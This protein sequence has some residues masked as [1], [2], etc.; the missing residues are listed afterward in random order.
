MLEGLATNRKYIWSFSKH[1]LY[2]SCPLALKYESKIIERDGELVPFNSLVGISFH[3]AISSHIVKW[4]VG[5]HS[6]EDD[7]E[8]IALEYLRY[9]WQNKNSKII[10]ILNGF[11]VSHDD[12]RRIE[13]STTDLI[14]HFFDYIWPRF[15]SHKYLTHEHLYYFPLSNFEVVVKPDLVTLGSKGS[16]VVTDWKTSGYRESDL[17]SFQTDIYGLWAY[18]FF[19]GDPSRIVTQI[20]NVRTGNVKIEVQTPEKLQQTRNEILRSMEKIKST[21][22]EDSTAAFPEIDKCKSCRFLNNCEYGKRL[23]SSS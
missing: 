9:L 10:E 5:E 19:T 6:E 3:K 4:S 22:G 15:Y 2:L 23:M 21:I 12:Q 11:N 17:S 8:K 20:I 18:N 1:E 16:V 13:Y 14:K 7:A